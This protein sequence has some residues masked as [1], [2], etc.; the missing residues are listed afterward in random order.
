MA[1]TCQKKK[2][3]REKKERKVVR[4]PATFP[5]TNIR[6]FFCFQLHRFHNAEVSTIKLRLKKTT[7]PLPQKF[8]RPSS[9][10]A[11][12][13]SLLTPASFCAL[14]SSS[15]NRDYIGL[16]RPEA[17]MQNRGKC[18][19]EVFCRRSSKNGRKREFEDSIER[20]ARRPLAM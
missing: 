14:F 10:T 11:Y 9:R 8:S 18:H 20:S 6:L 5:L 15:R 13:P 17:R 3:K 12:F 16:G 2:R 7:T 1:T 4:R 19:A